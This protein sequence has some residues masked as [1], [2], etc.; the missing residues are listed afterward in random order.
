MKSG[1][2]LAGKYR[3]ARQLGEGGEGS[4]FLAMHLQTELFWAIKEIHSFEGCD[5]TACHELQMMKSLKNRHLPQIIDVIVQGDSFFLVMEHVRGINMEK[6]IRSAGTIGWKEAEDAAMQVTEALCYLSDRKQP[7]FHLD[8]KP[9]NLI[10]RPDGLIVLVDFGAAWDRRGRKG[11]KGTDG[12][13]APEQYPSHSESPDAR[14]DIYGLGATL[15]RMITG[16]RYDPAEAARCLEKASCPAAF[17]EILLRCLARDPGERFQSAGELWRALSDMRKHRRK[18]TGRRRI[19]GALAIVLPASAF[20]LQT[21]PGELDLSKDENWNYDRILEQTSV[22]D[23]EESDE[24]YR[25]A[26][27]LDPGNSRAYLNYLED[28]G[29]DGVFSEEEDLFLRDLLHTIPLNSDQTY[30]ELLQADPDAYGRTALE[31]GLAYWYTSSRED[32]KRIAKGWFDKAADAAEELKNGGVRADYADEAERVKSEEGN[33]DMNP[34]RAQVEGG[35]TGMDPDTPQSEKG[36]AE[37][38]PE[39]RGEWVETAQLYL[40]LASSAE[41]VRAAEGVRKTEY[42]WDYWNDLEELG[43][44]LSGRNNAADQITCLNFCL[45]ALSSI[46]FL[47][48]DLQEA[49]ID[50]ARQETFIRSMRIYAQEIRPE[51][52]Q[53]KTA[54]QILGQITEAESLAVQA[55]DNL[56]RD[57]NS[58]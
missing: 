44:L 28:A 58:K 24:L 9:S 12:Y 36:K 49:G 22:C 6:K 16:Q 15:Y 48:K 2:T 37:D 23:R 26:V 42:V 29:L 19:L 38:A 53:E 20:C 45:E 39:K 33:A 32:A 11:G 25:R 30:E 10:V 47:A 27:F 5:E 43:E 35:N 14:S 31:I 57:E 4:V 41:K 34:D 8:I 54:E 56:M 52:R 1:D 7:V 18:K 3:I 40:R 46:P 50:P 55:A 17:S 13:A 51:K 21:V